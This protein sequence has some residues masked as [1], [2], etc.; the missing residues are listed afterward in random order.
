[1]LLDFSHVLLTSIS[2]IKIDSY[3]VAQTVLT[4]LRD[5][6]PFFIPAPSK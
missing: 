4:H 5:S 6:F 2:G 1:M 3:F